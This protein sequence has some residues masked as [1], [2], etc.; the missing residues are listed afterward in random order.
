MSIDIFR[1]FLMWCTIINMGFLAVWLVFF[2][3]ARDR[4]YGLHSR[5]FRLSP[6]RFDAVHYTGMAVYKST[7]FVFNL[8]PYVVLLIIGD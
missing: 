8:V 1:S 5:W 2:M 4:M 7:I 3:V 6:E